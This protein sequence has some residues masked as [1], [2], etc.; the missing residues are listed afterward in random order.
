MKTKKIIKLINNERAN[1][2]ITSRK[3]SDFCPDPTAIDICTIADYAHCTLYAYDK[4]G[5]DYAS[6]SQG[7]IDV[8]TGTDYFGCSGPGAHD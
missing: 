5:I 6:C 4:C 1:P 2:R 7:A 8:C 3:A